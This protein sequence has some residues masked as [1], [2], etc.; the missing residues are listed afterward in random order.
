ME[1]VFSN[2]FLKIK[3]RIVREISDEK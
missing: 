2:Y 3:K 1:S